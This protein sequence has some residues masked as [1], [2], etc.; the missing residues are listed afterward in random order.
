M[1]AGLCTFH[2]DCKRVAELFKSPFEPQSQQ[3]VGQLDAERVYL[4]SKLCTEQHGRKN[5]FCFGLA[6]RKMA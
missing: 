3:I 1:E 2:V 6:A 5:M 4:F